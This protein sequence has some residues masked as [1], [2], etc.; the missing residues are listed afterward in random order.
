MAY[1]LGVCYRGRE[2]E[3]GAPHSM[4]YLDQLGKDTLESEEVCHTLVKELKGQ[5]EEAPNGAHLLWRLSRA[6][7]HLSMHYEQQGRVEEEKQLLV[8][9]KLGIR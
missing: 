9:G 2:D 5:L 7:V 8:E 3:E 6:L 4:D 1:Y